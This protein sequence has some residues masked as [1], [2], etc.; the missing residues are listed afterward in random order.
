MGDIIVKGGY[1]YDPANGIDGEKVDIH[2]SGSKVVEEI[3]ERGVK[4]VD[5]SGMLVMPGGV[6]LHSHIAGSKINIGRVMRP[7]DHRKDPVPRTRVTRAGVGYSC[8]STFVAGYRYAQM[9]YTTVMEAAMPPIGAR[10]VHEELNDTPIFDKGA[11]PLFGNN[12][13]T[14]KYVRDGDMEMLKAFIAWLLRATKGYAV[15][16]VNPGGVENWKWGKNVGSLDDLVYN[17]EVTPRQIITSLARANEELGLPHTIHLHCNNLGVP[18]NYETTIETMDAVRSIKP[19]EGRKNTIHVVH[20]QFNALDGTNWMNVRSGASKIAKYVNANPHA[21]IDLGQAIFTDTTTMTGDGP[22]QFRLWNITGNKWVNSDVE[23]E[24][25]AGVVPYSF[26]KNNPA[27]AIQWAIGL[28]LALHIYDPWRVYMTTD[29]PNGGPFVFYPQV[30]SWLMSRKARTDTMLEINKAVM[31]RTT[32]ANVYREYTFGEIATVTRAATA[33]VLG[34][35]DKGHL[36]PGADGDVSVYHLDPTTWRP[37]MYS[38]LE[39]AFI[40]TAYTIKAGDIVVKDGEVM[41]TPLGT[42]FWA[43]ARVPE[44]VEAE[45]MKDLEEE[46]GRHYTVGLRN[47]PVEDAYLPTQKAIHTGGD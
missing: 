38:D 44:D 27:N 17:F 7:E 33:R 26:K 30:I 45:F 6:D 12:H 37:S 1:V 34:L 39:K 46:F 5:A 35:K 15:K 29:H 43:D 28:E 4:V 23:M 40:R 24:A 10:H 41:A 47:Y 14:L 2:I 32:L 16:I 11:F 42:T 13:F 25:G 22:W 36:G 21:T 31:R 8:P 19:K 18:G 20:V 3:R 9:G